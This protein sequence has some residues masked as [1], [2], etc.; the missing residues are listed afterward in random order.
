MAL[1]ILGS[2]LPNAGGVAYGDGTNLVFTPTGNTNQILVSNGTGAPS[3]I[4][5]ANVSSGIAQTKV[6]AISLIFGS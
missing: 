1:T 3:W 4:N 6:T 5:Q 2:N